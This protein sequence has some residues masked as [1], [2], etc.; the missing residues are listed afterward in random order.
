M[1]ARDA[2]FERTNAWVSHAVLGR[3][4]ARTSRRWQTYAGRAAFAATLIAVV[5]IGIWAVV[6]APDFVDKAN[7]GWVG[8]GLFVTFNVVEVLLAVFVAPAVVSRAVIEERLDGT[9]P[10]L[11]LTPIRPRSLLAGKVGARILVLF[12]VVLGVT[13]LLALVTTLGGVSASEVVLGTVGALVAT[14]T[15]G[16]L[17][18]FFGLFTRS[19]LIATLATV[20]WAA[21]AYLLVP[22]FYALGVASIF[23]F[24]HVSPLFAMTS[25]GWWGLLVVPLHIP[26]LLMVFHY[27]GKLF[28]LRIS[29]AALVR[30]FSES[31]WNTSRFLMVLG[32]YTAISLPIGFV[33]VIGSWGARSLE[34][35]AGG[36]T[37]LDWLGPLLLGGAARGLG[38]LWTCFGMTLLTWLYLR[39]GMDMVDALDGLLDHLSTGRRRRGSRGASIWSN[40]V[41]WRST[42]VSSWG[43]G[44]LPLL[45][46][47]VL[48]LFGLFQTGW[49]LIPGGLLLLGVGNVL[50][51]M[52]LTAWSAADSIAAERRTKTLEMLASTT[53]ATPHIV[54]GKLLVVVIPSLPMLLVSTLLLTVGL[55]H[56]GMLQGTDS[57]V[58][59]LIAGVL[60]G[61]WLVPAWG[62]VALVSTVVALRVRNPSASTGASMTTCALIFGIPAVWAAATGSIW[63][64]A[65]PG[66]LLVP[67][68]VLGASWWEFVLS[69]AFWSVVDLALVALLIARFRQWST[70]D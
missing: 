33:V 19:P 26:I 60:S 39:L 1:S 50:A 27:A 15:L 20:G 43:A 24:A 70:G 41:A 10:L 35:S 52:G 13:P 34:L 36:G 16:A 68:T 49:W 21:V 40:P 5:L 56:L 62:T 57:M 22:P 64:L 6:N 63:W 4:A 61:V 8:R 29:N 48:V 55:P 45:V 59:G 17:G 44:G 7:L 30:Y 23:A 65:L 28:E 54:L 11:A 14:V 2:I 66:R 18:G 69:T 38:W 32:S 51:L 47:W 31:V 46:G 37:P 42:R 25:N 53:L 9:L 3:E 12:T 67:I 58:S